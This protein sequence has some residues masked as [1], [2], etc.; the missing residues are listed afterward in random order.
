[1]EIA[2]AVG[3]LAPRLNGLAALGLTAL[4]TGALVTQAA[5]LGGTPVIE[6][7]FLIATA[8]IAYTRRADLRSPG[9]S[10]LR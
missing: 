5:V 7:V 8:A 4:M 10:R 9:S 2:G 1:L 6:V 3:L